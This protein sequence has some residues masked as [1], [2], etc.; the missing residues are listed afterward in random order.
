MHVSRNK[1]DE[2]PYPFVVFAGNISNQDQLTC[3]MMY[4]VDENTTVAII[5]TDGYS[6]YN[7]SYHQAKN[8]ETAHSTTSLLQSS[9][10][11]FIRSGMPY[12]KEPNWTCNFLPLVTHTSYPEYFLRSSLSLIFL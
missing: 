10:P 12:M 6:H 5:C 11:E 8:Q 1:D 7:I 4:T 9:P 2:V 3:P